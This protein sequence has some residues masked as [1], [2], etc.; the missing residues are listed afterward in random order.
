ML[1]LA[2]Q[3]MDAGICQLKKVFHHRVNAFS[4]EILELGSI[5]LYCDKHPVIKKV[6]D[7]KNGQRTQSRFIIENISVQP[8][9][10]P[11]IEEFNHIA[12]ELYSARLGITDKSCVELI[13]EYDPMHI[14]LAYDQFE[15]ITKDKGIIFRVYNNALLQSLKN[16]EPRLLQL[17]YAKPTIIIDCGHGGID[18]GTIGINKAAEKDIVLAIGKK[19]EKLLVSSG[20]RVCMTRNSDTFIPLDHRT[21]C[22]NDCTRPS[23]FISLHA[24][25]SPKPA[26]SGVETYCL[27]SKLFNSC[28]RTS[29][30]VLIDPL[31]DDHYCKS[32]EF[33]KSL[34]TALVDQLHQQYPDIVDRKVRPAVAQVLVG[35]TMPSTLVE[36]GYLSHNQEANRLK[37]AEY[38]HIIAQGIC[39]G[40]QQFT[41]AHA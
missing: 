40:I 24:N 38:Q 12:P 8:S 22:A 32:N 1:L 34:H 21:T 7:D 36:L 15:A 10:Q 29:I 17:S 35:T 16:K 41:Q 14:V 26:S 18:S 13:I 39:N 3:I 5:V 19:L 37:D 33:A 2:H 11:M 20:F 31:M 25:S 28:L 23:L 9:A 6:A 27:S 4:R 30:D